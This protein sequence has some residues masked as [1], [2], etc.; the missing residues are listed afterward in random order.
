MAKIIKFRLTLDVDYVSN[1]ES[2]DALKSLLFGVPDYLAN[3][4]L[5]TQETN[6]EV[7]RWAWQVKQRK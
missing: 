1:G 6:A 5:L 7:N 3:R 4:G 2:K